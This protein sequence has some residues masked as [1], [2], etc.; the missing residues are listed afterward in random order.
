MKRATLLA[1]LLLLPLSLHSAT[2]K[3]APPAKPVVHHQVKTTSAA[4]Q[5][6]FDRG[7]TFVYGFNHEEAIR[8]FKLAAKN[9]PHLAMAH[10]GIALALGPNINLD[11][12]P[13]R[14]KE[15]FDEAK[16][17]AA[18]KKYASPRERDYIDA[19][20]KRYSIDPIADLKK[21]AVDYHQAMGELSKKYPD[22]LDA[23]TLYAES[24]MDL[25]PWQ[26]W[27]KDGS[28]AEG[29]LEI[30]ATLESVLKRS[31]K[32]VGA[33]HYYIHAVEASPHPERA[34][35]SADVIGGLVPDAGHLVHMPSHIYMRVGKYEEASIANVKAAEADRA[36]IAKQGA[37]G[38]YPM[39]Y[40]SHNLDFLAAARAMEGR[41]A[42]AKKAAD[43]LME[44]VIP[45][46]DM[47]AMLEPFLLRPRGVLLRFGKWDEILTI[48][49]PP[50]KHPSEHAFWN[51]M[52]GMA[53]AAKG[54]AAKA[55]EAATAFDAERAK[56]PADTLL[57]LN[58]LSGVFDISANLLAARRARLAGDHDAEIGA[59]QKAV[60]GYD[61]MS[62]DEPPDFYY[63]P[64]ESLGGALLRANRPTEA[65]VI[66]R[67]ELNLNPG[68]GRALFGLAAAL[69]QANDPGAAAI[70][71]QFK[72]A[73]KNADVELRVED[74]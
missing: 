19:L 9:D 56:T 25:R 49:E 3:P 59:L 15:A 18:L 50:T 65:A 55:G 72:A 57:G 17:A 43:Q 26:L 16:K 33:N 37:D 52:R 32:H 44:N 12:D 34:L 70:E 5:G 73:W 48:P 69:R 45:A 20:R 11:V 7:L 63:S 27:N 51:F 2:R 13:D 40:Y 28:P 66:F 23:A 10:W 35:A 74:L 60:S 14:E 4:A 1:I 30:I 58:T 47:M 53:F 46:A 42:D 36:Y 61:A 39:M 8:H 41:Y 62:Y 31:P 68:N 24:G 38:V 22:D 54:D 6:E 21:L 67:Q 71:E 64:R 29:T